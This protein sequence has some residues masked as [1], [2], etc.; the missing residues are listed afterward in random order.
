[1]TTL[2]LATGGTLACTP[3]PDGKVF[4]SLDGRDLLDRVEGETTTDD[5]IVEDLT[6]PGSWN[7]GPSDRAAVALRARRALEEGEATGVVITHGTDTSEETTWMCD[8]LAGAATTA[9]PIVVTA[10]MR[11]AAEFGAEGPRNIVDALA[12]ARSGIAD[13]GA[14]LCVNGEIHHGRHVTKTHTT[15]VATFASPDRGPIGSVDER[16]V[17]ITGV[18]P[19]RPPAPTSIESRVE[20]IHSYGG[21][22][23]AIVDYHLQAGAVGLV[24]VGHGAGNVQASVARRLDAALDAGVAIVV[25]SRCQRGEV[26]AVYGGEGGGASLAEVGVIGGH[27]LTPTKARIALCVALANGG[28]TAAARAYFAALDPNR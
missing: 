16:G 4:T 2:L 19:P 15:N 22:D 24:L 28:G 14:V 25:T 26:A 5:V 21:I 10:A 1:M 11:H 20:I 3:G 7:A 12:V 9:G 27:E 13:L 18:A 8:L 23:G 6:F 17:R